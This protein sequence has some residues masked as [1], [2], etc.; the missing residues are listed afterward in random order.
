M[1]FYLHV[2]QDQKADN[3]LL[4][5]EQQLDGSLPEIK[6]QV[7]FTHPATELEKEEVNAVSYPL[8]RKEVEELLNFAQQ[9]STASNRH[10]GLFA[11]GKVDKKNPFKIFSYPSV[12]ELSTL[13]NH[14]YLDLP[15]QSEYLTRMIKPD[16]DHILENKH[17]IFWQKHL[18]LTARKIVDDSKWTKLEIEEIDLLNKLNII[19]LILT[20]NQKH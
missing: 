2:C 10:T 1:T 6:A 13:L 11:Q 16:L 4:I 8:S 5:S 17:R 20:E 12:I 14:F 15:Q 9:R 7:Y 18:P 3:F 19:D